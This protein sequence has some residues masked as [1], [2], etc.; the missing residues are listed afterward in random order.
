MAGFFERGFLE[1]PHEVLT[2]TLV[3]HQHYFPVLTDSGELKEAFLAVV[4]TQPRTS[5]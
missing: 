1:L 3:H 5:G 2:T 4:N